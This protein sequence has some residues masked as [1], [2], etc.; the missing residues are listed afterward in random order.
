AAAV[1][2]LAS[3]AHPALVPAEVLQRDPGRLVLAADL[4]PVSLR[5]RFQEWQAR[6]QPG[7]PRPHLLALLGPVTPA[8]DPPAAQ[9]SVHPLGITPR[10]LLLGEG[11]R[12]FIADFGLAELLWAPAGQAVARLNARYAAPEL[13]EKQAGRAGDQYSLALVYAEMLTGAHPF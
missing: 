9:P 11:D 13:C 3:L 1:A 7:I 6:G 4:V 2:R 12:P 8:L 10:N 5:D